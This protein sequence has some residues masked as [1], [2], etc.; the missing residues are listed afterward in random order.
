MTRKY[1]GWIYKES[2]PGVRDQFHVEWSSRPGIREQKCYGVSAGA[3]VEFFEVRE[4]QHVD[5]EETPL[6][7]RVYVLT[8]EDVTTCAEPSSNA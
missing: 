2:H 8:M 3:C 4:K 5:I 6:G 1:V 7:F